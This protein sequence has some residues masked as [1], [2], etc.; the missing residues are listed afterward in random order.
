MK[1]VSMSK[2]TFLLPTFMDGQSVKQIIESLEL[3]IAQ[4]HPKLITDYVIVDESLGLDQYL[5]EYLRE[6]SNSTG[7][8]TKVKLLTPIYRR[9]NQGAI[10]W[11]LNQLPLD[12]IDDKCY[13]V[14]MDSDGE[15]D[16]RDV[17]RLLVELI[18]NNL[19]LVYAKRG[20]R[21]AK[22]SF[23]L[24]K[25][26]YSSIFRI[27]TGA[28]LES[29]N[30]SAMKLEWLRQCM[31]DGIFSNSFSGELPRIQARK[32]KIICNRLPRWDG[33]SKT[34]FRSLVSI[35]LRQLIPW[36]EI[37]SVRSFIF[38]VFSSFM[39]TFAVLS[40]FTLKLFFGISTPSWATLVVGFSIV[41]S[42]LTF[43]LFAISMSIMVQI[44]GIKRLTAELSSR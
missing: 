24:G 17:P 11:A 22:L 37:I 32:S 41:I 20:S 38:F 28:Q 26:I 18:Q 31:R 10:L 43:L 25:I 9:G 13:L 39:A 1:Q 8:S 5:N 42:L 7:M 34:N 15:D 27:L 36:S 40:A 44:D 19:D 35:A 12:S 6:V 16:P 4:M 2:V 30:F 23:R 33:Q 14:V 3:E 29:G 21:S